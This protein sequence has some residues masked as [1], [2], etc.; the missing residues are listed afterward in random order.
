MARPI[1]P[2]AGATGWAATMAGAINDV[3]DR[4]D[5]ALAGAGG[6]PGVVLLDSFAGATDDDK[7]T[8]ALSYCAAQTQIPAVMLGNRLHN[9]NLTRTPFS[10]MKIIGGPGGPRNPELAGGKYITSRVK[11]GCGSGTSSW[12]VGAA[13][14]YDIYI[15][16]IGF[17]G[18]SGSA[19]QQFWEQPLGAGSLYACEFHALGFDFM[20]YV[21]GRPSSMAAL[22]QVLFTG[23][24]TVNNMWDTQFT[25]GGSD[26]DLWMSGYCNLGVSSSPAQT[27]TNGWMTVLSGMTNTRLGYLYASPLNGWNGW[28]ITGNSDGLDIYGGVSEGYKPDNRSAPGSVLRIDGGSGNVFG[29]NWGQGMYGGD[30]NSH[31]VVEVTGG[32]W[33]FWG[34][35]FYR[36][37]VAETVPMIYQSGG[38]ILVMGAKR[39]QAESW[40]GRPRLQSVGGTYYMPDG[41]MTAI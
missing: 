7:L 4:A 2:V 29:G 32:E 16:D 24:W 1:L 35:E 37:S 38:R 3:S 40:T 26:N 14:Y 25:I 30:P 39:R 8:A 15:A 41:S 13:T 23:H 18:S 20:R 9:F 34:P 5:L 36:G 19:A 11:L 27:G 17:S 6:T 12:F 22:T 33:N 28:K 31:G 21:F 10:G